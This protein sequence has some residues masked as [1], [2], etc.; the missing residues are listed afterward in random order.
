MCEYDGVECDSDTSPLPAAIADLSKVNK[1]L[2]NL[3]EWQLLGLHLGL[4]YR[5][6]E[7]IK[8]DYHKNIDEC[9]MAML[10]AWLQQQDDVPQK[11][12]PSWLVLQ[13]ALE[14][15][16]DNYHADKIL[17]YICMCAPPHPVPPSP[18]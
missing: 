17:D 3:L 2:K 18:L 4:R 14:K 5:T 11:R 6:L 13:A 7:K 9:K 15:M 1:V 16:D 8:S 12:V 10:T